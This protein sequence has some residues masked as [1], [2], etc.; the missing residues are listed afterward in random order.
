[1]T[2]KPFVTQGGGRNVDALSPV[3]K[4]SGSVSIKP[5]GTEINLSGDITNVSEMSIFP[6]KIA[7]SVNVT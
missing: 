6:L 2:P 5:S 3:W 1:M 4:A 7:M